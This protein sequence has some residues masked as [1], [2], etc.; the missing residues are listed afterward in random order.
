[1]EFGADARPD[2][3]G[4]ARWGSRFGGYQHTRIGDTH[5]GD[6]AYSSTGACNPRRTPPGTIH[7]MRP[8]VNWFHPRIREA[9][10]ASDELVTEIPLQEF[11]DA[12]A[13]LVQR[14][15]TDDGLPLTEHLDAAQLSLYRRAMG[16]LRIP[17]AMFEVTEP[18]VPT[19]LL[20]SGTPSGSPYRA[21]I[22]VERILARAA[23]DRR[24]AT[25]GLES[26]DM[27][28]G[29]FDNL[30]METQVSMLMDLSRAIVE[31]CRCAGRRGG[32]DALVNMWAAGDVD[33]LAAANVADAT[34]EPAEFHQVLLPDRNDR[35]S[36]W[37]QLRLNE[38]GGKF[39]VAVGAAHLAGDESVQSFLAR[40]GITAE[41]IEY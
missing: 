30:S 15:I 37:I 34:E 4:T 36:Q 6:S 16:R 7:V 29:F 19:F 10:N 14:A 32:I 41:R 11:E 39:F 13:L 9:F 27:Q 26:L 3:P 23:R 8:G 12:Q 40:D 20:M 28:F 5:R 31:P 25:S 22:G 1:M 17:V 24:M 35:S 18:W 21:E 33:S 38:P 2:W